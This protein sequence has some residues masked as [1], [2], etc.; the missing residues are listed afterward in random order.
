MR[1]ENGTGATAQRRSVRIAAE[2]DGGDFR[3]RGVAAVKQLPR[4]QCF[5]RR[6]VIGEV[7]RLA[8]H[9][10]VPGY[11][12]PVQIFENSSDVG[13]AA[14]RKIYVLDAQ[15]Q[16]SARP[17]RQF[18]VEKRGESMTAVQQP[19]RAWSEAKHRRRFAGRNG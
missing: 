2:V 4:Q 3:A 5:R 1:I 17:T 18:P 14:A 8:A 12:E 6:R 10:P 7:A 11:S 13:L 9:R 19:V 15:Q 16:A